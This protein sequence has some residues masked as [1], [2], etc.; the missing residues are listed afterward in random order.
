[1]ENKPKTFRIFPWQ[2]AAMREIA[3]CNNNNDSAEMRNAVSNYIARHFNKPLTKDQS[4]LLH[5][6]ARGIF[7]RGKKK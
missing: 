3:G 1:M 5:F 2:L 6:K 7:E 4:D